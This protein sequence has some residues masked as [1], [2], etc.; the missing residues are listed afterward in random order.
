MRSLAQLPGSLVRYAPQ[1]GTRSAAN[2]KK[3]SEVVSPWIAAGHQ[4]TDG[5]DGGADAA[6][7]A[8]GSAEDP[9]GL[10]LREGVFAGCPQPGVRA[11]ELLVTLG[12]FAVV[13]V[14]GADGGAGSLVGAVGQDEDL[15]GEAGL[16]DAVSPRGGQVVCVLAW[17]WRPPLVCRRNVR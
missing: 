3:L 8:S 1:Y 15:P 16:D 7:G 17:P 5:L 13:V 14:R 6:G 11:I 10:Q 2:S 9:P 12:L 4:R